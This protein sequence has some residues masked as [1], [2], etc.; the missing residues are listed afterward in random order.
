MKSRVHNRKPGRPGEKDMPEPKAKPWLEWIDGKRVNLKG[1]VYE[2]HTTEYR[3]SD[4][5]QGF[6]SLIAEAERRI[7][8]L[9]SSTRVLP[10][11]DDEG[12]SDCPFA[13][14]LYTQKEEAEEKV[15]EI[16]G[17]LERYQ[18]LVEKELA[19]CRRNLKRI[20]LDAK[21]VRL[22]TVKDKYYQAANAQESE[23]LKAVQQKKT[24]K[25]LISRCNEVLANSRKKRWP[26]KKPVKKEKTRS[27]PPVKTRAMLQRESQKSSAKSGDLNGLFSL[28]PLPGKGQSGGK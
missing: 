8:A 28:G 25:E 4:L 12:S 16:I 14:N 1:G 15:I 23:Y 19:R 6:D 2:E 3:G 17:R 20:E 5:H 21:T 9:E 22:K 27:A 26:G 18:D 7:S 24:L 11:V 10:K 13:G